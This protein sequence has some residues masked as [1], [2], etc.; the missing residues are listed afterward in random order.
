MD[1]P[2]DDWLEPTEWKRGPFTLRRSNAGYGWDLVFG[3][4]VQL[5]SRQAATP[6]WPRFI[7]GADENCNRAVT[8]VLWPFGSVDVWWEP[9][10]RSD[11]DGP[12]DVCRA[13]F[14]AEGCCEWCGSRPCGCDILRPERSTTSA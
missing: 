6:M 5:R 8:L 12:C 4:R 11:G 1:E 9:M 10:L 14:R 13:E 3:H 2:M 7:K